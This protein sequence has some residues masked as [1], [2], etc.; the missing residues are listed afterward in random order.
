M[1]KTIPVAVNNHQLRCIKATDYKPLDI[2]E[3]HLPCHCCGMKGSWYVEKLTA[4]RRARPK[5]DQT[6]RR[7]CRKCY[8]AVVRWFRALALSLPGMIDFI[9]MEPT[10]SEYREVQQ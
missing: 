9:G 3:P 1:L 10:F 4:E 2:T 8:D 6:A 7:V 5:D